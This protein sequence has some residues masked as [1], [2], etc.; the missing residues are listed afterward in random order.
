MHH[1]ELAAQLAAADPEQ[2][3]AL[4]A[5]HTAVD[6]TALAWA[7]KDLCYAAWTS[8]PRRSIAA[9]AA[10]A[11][12]AARHPAPE[13]SAL[14]AWTAGIAALL[15]GQMEQAVER[16]NAAAN[17]FRALNQP[18]TAAATQVGKLIALALL[19]RYDEA[20][21]C[22]LAA[23]DVFLAHGDEAAAG[24]I[25]QNL[26]GIYGRRDRYREAEQ[27]YR[28]ARARF[29]AAGDRKQ[30]AQIDNCIAT[31]L[32]YQHQFQ[33]AERT[34]KQA[35]DLARV[36]GQLVTR[37][38]IES[39]LGLLALFRGRYTRALTYL[40]RAR[41]RYTR[42]AMPHESAIAEQL[43]A[44]A[45]LELNMAAEAAAVY[46]RLA[47]AFAELS[48]RFEQAWTLANHGRACLLLGRHAD[49]RRLLSAA[50]ALFAAEDNA[51]CVAIVQLA[52]A[53]ADHA[54]GAYR[55]AFA[56]AEEAEM[57][58]AAAGVWQ[59]ALTGR[60]LRGDA[61]RALGEVAAAHELLDTTLVM[62]E[63]RTLPQIAQRCLTSL[64]LLAAA[65][66]A[67]AQAA[68]LFERSAAL[69]EELR[70]P[71]PAEEFRTAFVADKLTPYSE[72][73]RLQLA[74]G[75]PPRARQALQYVERARSRALVDMLGGVVP[76]LPR[77]RD[78]FEARLLRE[79]NRLRDELNWLY[80]QLNRPA[81]GEAPRG[82]ADL[83]RLQ[84]Q[85]A[86]RE[87][88]ILAITRQ[89]QQHGSA[90]PVGVE[91]L[92]LEQLQR[93]LGPDTAL[94]EY[95]VLDDEL[96]AFVV[97]DSSVTA[98]RN[99]GVVASVEAVVAQLRFQT[100]TLRHGSE[101]MAAH[102]GQLARRAEHYLRR[103]YDQLLRPIEALLGERR[104]V[105]VPHRALHYVPFQALYDGTQYLVERREVCYA[106]SA[107]VLRHCLRQSLRPVE[108]A[109]L[110]G[111]PDAQIPRV[112]DEVL[113]LAP[114]FPQATLLLDDQAT[115]AALRSHATT[116]AVVHL[117]CHGQFRPDNPL[118]SALRLGDGWL[119]VRDAYSLRLSCELVVLSACETGVNAVAPGDDMIGLA[120]GFF[121]AG[122]PAILVS[123]WTVDDAST[124]QLM[125]S[126]YT[127]LRAGARAAAALR[128]AQEELRQQHPHPYF[129][130]PFVL[131]GRW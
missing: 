32:M 17:R 73:V 100:D 30:L 77:S 122:A 47:P 107:A 104:L 19:G 68:E 80:T 38:E 1:H 84:Q 102:S 117:A 58:F 4:L 113:A 16:L 128:A 39:N 85:V 46:E 101:R 81:E 112:R 103:L 78:G 51:I 106:P 91:P 50:R 5:Q 74:A 127:R 24:R 22:G 64:G 120:R 26:G 41:R 105:V 111:V 65:N 15:A 28:S 55:A 110:V 43:L 95:F 70:A 75:D 13:I 52:E 62:A 96:L 67:A 94:V 76:A 3:S 119:T 21:N 8:E 116:A 29:V 90:A 48:M 61:L 6:L 71:L 33:A 45:Y 40:E 12:L 124:A 125:T 89:L 56:A 11:D 97:T 36:E 34:Y 27:L 118:F 60:W 54:A 7:L 63:Q 44:D 49:M 10:L 88:A 92:D 23:R 18:V 82:A 126:F 123:L 69:V 86:D 121:Y 129:W 35:L 66:G 53:Q 83:E 31:E 109:L 79:L 99:L 98:V 131:M 20:I 114:L 57:T 72:L 93:D 87:H 25:E 37:A 9:A 115:L 2:R 130:S 59:R 14:A 108:Q 42:L